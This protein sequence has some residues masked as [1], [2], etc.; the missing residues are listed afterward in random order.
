MDYRRLGYAA[1]FVVVI[2]AVTLLF[3]MWSPT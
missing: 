1:G 2:C 3:I